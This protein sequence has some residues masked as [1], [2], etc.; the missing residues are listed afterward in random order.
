MKINLVF[1]GQGREPA[2]QSTSGGVIRQM[3]ILKRLSKKPNVVL[4]IVT[5]KAYCDAFRENHVKAIYRVTPYFINGESLA[6]IL[7]DSI[8]RSIYASIAIILPK[9]GNILIYSPSDFLWDTFPAY[10]W[11]LRSKHLKWVQVVHH[12][13]D[14]P[15][16]RKGEKFLTNLLGFL[17]QRMSLFLI[18]RKADAVIVVSPL[19]RQCLRELGFDSRKV[20]VVYNGIDKTKIEHFEPSSNRLKKYDCVFLGRLNVS[21]GLFDL[22]EIWRVLLKN[23]PNAS[24]AIIGGGN[25]RMKQEL[26]NRVRQYNLQENISILGYL[27]DK[28]AFGILKSSR[29]FVFPSYEEGFGIAILEAMACG[30]PVV[31]WDLPVY[32]AIFQGGMITAPIKNT[33]KFA[34]TVLELLENEQFRRRLSL[35]ATKTS[36]KYDWN[37]VA[38][39]ELDLIRHLVKENEHHI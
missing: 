29:I 16:R 35:E 33:Q 3:E 38:K 24:L 34:E 26:E 23:A 12:L 21:K 25:K 27:G 14:S 8:L 31:A 2:N 9:G 11:K 17:S 7:L 22:I 6:E 32:K 13:Y 39:E 20:R 36:S 18:R 4:W 37:K 1:N 28:E 15:F 19:V 5:S 30:L 10:V